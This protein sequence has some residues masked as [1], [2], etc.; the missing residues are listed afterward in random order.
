MQ[1]DV[2]M[3]NRETPLVNTQKQEKKPFYYNINT[4]YSMW[5]SNPFFF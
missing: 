5:A 1:W 2:I 4:S 3:Q